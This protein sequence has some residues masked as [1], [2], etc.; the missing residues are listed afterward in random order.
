MHAG[1]FCFQIP[2]LVDMDLYL[3]AMT[4][5]NQFQPTF[6]ESN[7]PF[8][9]SI[10]PISSAYASSQSLKVMIPYPNLPSRYDAKVMSAQ[11]GRTGIISTWTFRG[12]IDGIGELSVI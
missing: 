10:W 1:S 5:S 8:A 4:S 2:A 9:A 11:K 12:K 7:L 3:L 6:L